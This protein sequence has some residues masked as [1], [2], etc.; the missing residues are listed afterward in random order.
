MTSNQKVNTKALFK[1]AYDI[2][3]LLKANAISPDEAKEHANLI[4]QSN[5][6]LKYELDKAKAIQKY[7]NIQITDI[8][9]S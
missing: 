5:N 8:E 1:H 6:L 3:K 7:E 4:K 9:E 2:M